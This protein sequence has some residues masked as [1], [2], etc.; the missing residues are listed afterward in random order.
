MTTAYQVQFSA[1]CDRQS[2]SPS[3]LRLD[4]ADVVLG[5]L[6]TLFAQLT[7]QGETLSIDTSAVPTLQLFVA[8]GA[9]AG[10]PA[11]GWSSP[12][13]AN[14]Y[15]PGAA[16]LLLA[17]YRLDTTA[18]GVGYYRVT[19]TVS[20]KDAGSNSNRYHPEMRLHVLAA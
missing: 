1:W 9:N 16:N 7:V 18:L 2:G 8:T 19:W 13:N 12:Q 6:I 3:A 15:T 4:E 11:P 17:E 10:N 14:D 20:T 5:E